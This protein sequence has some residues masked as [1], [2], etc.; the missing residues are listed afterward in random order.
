MLQIGL[1]GGMSLAWDNQPLSLIA[2]TRARALFAYLVLNRHVLHHRARL[3]T[4][5]WPDLPEPQA[6]RRLRQAL[7][8]VARRVNDLPPGPYLL[9]DGNQVRFDATLPH[10][11]D[12]D[13]FDRL[14]QGDVAEMA[15]AVRLYRPL[16]PD[17][18]EDWVLLERERL[19]ERWLTLLD[20]LAHAYQAQGDPQTA[21]EM[22]RMLLQ[23]EPWHEP[24]ARLLMTLLAGQGRTGEALQTYLDLRACL[25]TDLNLLPTAETSALYN[26]LRAAHPRTLSPAPPLPSPVQ[27]IV[28]KEETATVEAALQSARQH[29]GQLILLTG[30]AGIGKTH[31]AQAA[32]RRAHDLG[33]WTLYTNAVEPFGPPAPY[34]PLDQALQAGLEAL[35]SL[36]PNLPPLAQAALSALLPGLAPAVPN[37]DVAHLA[38]AHFHAALAKGLAGL[39]EPGPLLLVL[40]DLHWADQATW[41][42]LQALLGHLDNCPLILIVSFRPAD[43][44]D[45]IA[46]WPDRLAT[47]S[48]ARALAL[49]PLSPGEVDQLASQLLGRPLPPTLA[50]QLH[51]ETGG[52]PLFVVE[53]VRGLMEEGDLRQEPDGQSSWPTVETLPI[54]PT[55]RQA[56]TAR[57]SHLTPGASHLLRQ[58]AILGDGFDFDLLSS[59]SGEEDEEALLEQLDELMG[60]R[61]L[62]EESDKYRF[63]HNLVRRVLYDES[64]PRRRRI[65]HRKA[66]EAIARLAPQQVAIRARHAHAAAEWPE[67]LQLTLAAAEQALALF[68]IEEAE[69]FY[70]LAQEAEEHLADE[71]PTARLRRLRGLARVHRLHSEDRA[72]AQALEEW[73]A[74]A[75]TLNDSSAEALALAGLA[76]NLR[77]QGRSGDGLPLAQ[78]AARLAE[79]DPAALATA[80]RAMGDCHEGLGDLA[81]ALSF[82][83]QAVDAASTAGDPQREAE[84]L[85]GL[86]IILENSGEVAEASEAYR[87]AAALAAS[88]GDRLTESRALNNLGT[89]HVLRGDYGPARRAYKD[90]LEGVKALDIREGQALVRG[91]LAEVWMLMGHLDTARAHLDE[92]LKLVT[93]L[94]WPIEHAKAL[95]NLAGWAVAIGKPE[96]ALDFVR[97]AQRVLPQ[98]ELQ[99]VHLYCCFQSA[100][101]HLALGDAAAAAEHAEQLAQQA[102]QTGMGWVAGQ[103][104]LLEGR[105]AAARGDLGAAEQHLRRAV[106]VCQAQGFRAN[107]AKARAELGL[108]LRCAGQEAE[109]AETLAAAWEELARRMMR[110]DLAQ[111]LDRLGR[112]PALPGQRE[113]HL[114]RTDAPLRRQPT[115]EECISILWTPDAGP[116]EPDLRRASL[117]RARL[118][119]LL[120]EAAVQQAVPTIR[121]LARAVAVSP[122][123]LNS[124]LAA[125]RQEGWPICTRGST[126]N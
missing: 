88:C 97:Q 112:P 79:D 35:G 37:L 75:Q 116:L 90:V 16:L 23:V 78:E 52:N 62:I 41:A 8:H 109:A 11:V 28:R 94:N 82:Y 73:R 21:I 98:Q 54:P 80:L 125:L 89:I 56:L 59:L 46:S 74:T 51:R 103:V 44:P 55:L 113:V 30:P 83:R 64:H 24:A 65:W 91:N 72:E 115:P 25:Q 38:P 27:P 106:Q 126:Q 84:C 81:T 105:V 92:T 32:A 5:F 57:L 108:A 68:A 2:S 6:R 22:A 61:L 43:L 53:T 114:P 40:D 85:N 17:I 86:A 121:D 31:L 3:A 7:W 77:R 13:V 58:A 49:S 48:A 104:A 123:T 99:Q 71:C 93:Q 100:R 119:R 66:A 117:R 10:Q 33:F 95:L 111:L 45:N 96:E 118:R 110:L 1:L 42:V 15:Q 9:R 36:P 29:Q 34:S 26:Q 70:R 12:V 19:H 4:L 18:Y 124:D 76:N 120:T 101:A 63:A 69:A 102:R 20:H 60:R 107:A 67:A 122:A 87:R 39:A 50:D 47:H 14:S